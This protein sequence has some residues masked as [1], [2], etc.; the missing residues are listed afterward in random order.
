MKVERRII[1]RR[2]GN[3]IRAL[4]PAED[5]LG[6]VAVERAP[7]GQDAVLAQEGEGKGR[8]VDKGARGYQVDGRVGAV[9]QVRVGVG[10]GLAQRG[11]DAVAVGVGYYQEA[12]LHCMSGREVFSVSFSTVHILGNRFE[13]VEGG[14]NNLL[15]PP[16]EHPAHP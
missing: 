12:V 10:V 15:V 13:S 5:G 7:V 9:D 16:K 4:G 6:G 3:S 1:A 11:R 14:Q 2:V 8:L